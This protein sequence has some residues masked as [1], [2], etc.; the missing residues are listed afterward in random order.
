M[1]I[2]KTIDKFENFVKKE[3]ETMYVTELTRNLDRNVSEY[4]NAMYR[5]LH[6]LYSLKVKETMPEDVKNDYTA[7]P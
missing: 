1:N 6:F 4:R 2:N 7:I 3:T 5:V